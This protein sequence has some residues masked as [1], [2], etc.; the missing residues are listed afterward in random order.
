MH[1]LTVVLLLVTF[2]ASLEASVGTDL[3]SV[4]VSKVFGSPNEICILHDH[5]D[6][7]WHDLVN[8]FAHQLGNHLCPVVQ[9]DDLQ[10]AERSCQFYLVYLEMIQFMVENKYEDHVSSVD[11]F[12]ASDAVIH[13]VVVYTSCVAANAF[14]NSVDNIDPRTGNLRI[15]TMAEPLSETLMGH[16]LS[17]T[18]PFTQRFKQVYDRLQEAGLPDFWMQIMR[19]FHSR[20][21]DLVV[22]MLGFEELISLWWILAYGWGS[23]GLALLGEYLAVN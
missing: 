16:T 7:R 12:L 11:E 9:L 19:T 1:T 10:L 5:R 20:N 13:T 2:D 21:P 17:R 3:A 18:E 4:V 23:A 14:V 22:T 15:Y 6:P 8:E